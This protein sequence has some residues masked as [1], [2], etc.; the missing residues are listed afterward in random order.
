MT[1][2]TAHGKLPATNE[3][4]NVPIPRSTSISDQV[5][6]T[7][8]SIYPLL[9]SKTKKQIG[10]LEQLSKKLESVTSKKVNVS[11]KPGIGFSTSRSNLFDTLFRR[12]AGLSK[13]SVDLVALDIKPGKKIELNTL[14]NNVEAS[15][16]AHRTLLKSL[17]TRPDPV[18]DPIK[19]QVPNAQVSQ[20]KTEVIKPAL[21]KRTVFFSPSA[22]VTQTL[23]LGP[24]KPELTAVM[25]DYINQLQQPAALPRTKI[26]DSL[27]TKMPPLT[28]PGLVAE[29]DIILNDKPRIIGVTLK[30]PKAP[31]PTPTVLQKDDPVSLTTKRPGKLSPERLAFWEQV[32]RSNTPQK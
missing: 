7:K 13:A 30:A 11:F 19:K 9:I 26:S 17:Q 24:D 31:S 25:D 20:P 21:A 3:N 32:A 8:N 28:S 6:S 4:T 2:I 1:V 10:E 5:N 22:T 27:Q 29:M 18:V 15:L 14:R 23:K 12:N 16:N